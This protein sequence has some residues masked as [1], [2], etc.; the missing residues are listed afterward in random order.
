MRELV[1]SDELKG[2]HIVLSDLSGARF[3]GGDFSNV[4]I[5]D[6][7]MANTE[8]SGMVAGL[9]VNGVKVAPLVEAELDRL[10]PER[11]ELRP[12]DVA[13]LRRAFAVVEAMWAPTIE[14]ARRLDPALLH[15]RVDGEY[16]FVET[17]RH[18]VFATDSWLTRMVLQIPNGHHPWGMPPDMTPDA[19]PDTG[20]DLD[21]VLALRA[22]RTAKVIA[23]VDQATEDDLVAVVAA[24]DSTAHPQGSRRV[25]DCFRVVFGEEWWHHRY[26]TRDLATLL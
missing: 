9:T 3:R 20:I 14:R 10:H 24:P 22:Q 4:K 15:Q 6:G 13:G 17:I 12:D 25:L 19:P 26:A 11:V 7:W 8:I 16:S 23:W 5:T 18:L 2:A 1:G 21:E